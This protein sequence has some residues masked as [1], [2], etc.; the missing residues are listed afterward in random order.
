MQDNIDNYAA[1]LCR[2]LGVADDEAETAQP[3]N[4]ANKENATRAAFSAAATSSSAYDLLL[5]SCYEQ[6][7][8]KLAS[9]P[10]SRKQQLLLV[11][12]LPP[13]SIPYESY[14]RNIFAS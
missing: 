1:L 9:L 4:A 2:H 7:M 3:A 8:Q 6:E 14:E 11:R 10:L 12:V 13:C 5:G